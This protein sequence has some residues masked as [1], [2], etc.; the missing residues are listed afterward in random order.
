MRYVIA[1]ENM[2]SIRPSIKRLIKKEISLDMNKIDSCLKFKKECEISKKRFKK[3]L[4][5]LKN[6]GKKI[7][8]YAAAA[9]STTVLN[10]CKIDNKIIDFIADSTKEKIGKFSPGT[11][12][13]IVSINY[14]KTHKPDIAV[15]FSWN[16]KKEILEKEKNFSKTGGKWISHVQ[17]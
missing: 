7:C 2:R 8:G 12:I 6:K 9:K 3:T 17:N 1:R 14:F 16:H 5:N 10:Y 11:H 15:L 4:E 13:P